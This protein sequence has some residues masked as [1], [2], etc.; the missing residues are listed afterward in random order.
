MSKV[1]VV[2]NDA[3]VLV[4]TAFVSL[5]GHV[6]T[7]Y[8]RITA[9]QFVGKVEYQVQIIDFLRPAFAF[10]FGERNPVCRLMLV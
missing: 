10:L 5:I 8:L 1:Y 9:W 4:W 6:L 3:D 7:E 2:H